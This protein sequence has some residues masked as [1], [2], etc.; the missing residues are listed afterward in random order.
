MTANEINGVL[1]SDLHF[2][3]ELMA[4]LNQI[5]RFQ[6]ECQAIGFNFADHQNII[7]NH[8]FLEDKQQD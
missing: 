7:H 6:I 5:D 1:G 2:L 4:K 3:T 8:P